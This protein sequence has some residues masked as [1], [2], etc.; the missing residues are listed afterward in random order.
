MFKAEYEDPT[1]FEENVYEQT[2]CDV[3]CYQP[4]TM[5]LPNGPV[6][7]IIFGVHDND[8]DLF[9]AQI[10]RKNRRIWSLKEMLD[11]NA[12]SPA[13]PLVLK[14]MKCDPTIH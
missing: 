8:V 1:A 3:R 11:D 6:P 4:T 13:N 5:T 2:G 10:D 9:E 14:Y 12:I 7:A